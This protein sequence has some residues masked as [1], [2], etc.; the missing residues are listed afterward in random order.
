MFGYVDA[1]ISHAWTNCGGGKVGLPP[2]SRCV[3]VTPPDFRIHAALQ[4]CLE[5]ACSAVEKGATAAGLV[6]DGRVFYDVVCQTACVWDS[7]QW[8]GTLRTPLL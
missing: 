6:R 5:R 3:L 7:S 2:P 4:P 1:G 8:M